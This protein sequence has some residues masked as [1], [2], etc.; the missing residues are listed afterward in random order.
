MRCYTR[1]FPVRA[2]FGV[3]V[4]AEQIEGALAP[5]R[6]AHQ[7]LAHLHARVAVAIAVQGQASAQ[8]DFGGRQCRQGIEGILPTFEVAMAFFHLGIELCLQAVGPF[9]QG[10][11]RQAADQW[12]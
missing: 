4:Y 8:V 6:Q 2:P 7:R 10:S 5:W 11:A 9:S 3:D 12:G 1:P